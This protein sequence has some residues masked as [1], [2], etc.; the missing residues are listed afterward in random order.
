MNLKSKKPI[1]GLITAAA[2]A[3]FA[4][5]ALAGECKVSE[6]SM[7]KPGGFPD[8]ALTMIV[9]YGPGGGSG[10]VAAAMAEAVSGLTASVNSFTKAGLT[11]G[12]VLNKISNAANQFAVSERDLIEGFKRSASVAELAGVSIDELGGIIT[13]VQQ[14]TA[15]GG[16]V[17]GNSFKTIFTRI[18]RSENLDLLRGLGIQITDVQG[19]ILPATKLIENLAK[20][21]ENLGDVEVREIT[22]KIGGGFQ[23]APLLAALS[24]YSSQ[25]SIAIQATQAFASASDQAYKKNEAL[26]QT[27]SAAINRTT[28]SV[29]ELANTLGELGVTDTFKTLLDFFNNLASGAEKILR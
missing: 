18:G 7:A 22:Q 1:S 8:R 9:P 19:K 15:R 11:T 13:A 29:K 28:L 4:G 10:Q 24:D 2:L 6:A 16:A 23:I 27:L 5:V 25:N 3:S 14:K 20:E 26:N 17:I 12:E 21:I